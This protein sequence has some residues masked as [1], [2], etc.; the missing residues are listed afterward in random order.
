LTIGQDRIL[1]I[2][3]VPI[4][5]RAVRLGEAW[6]TLVKADRYR[7]DGTPIHG[8]REVDLQAGR[9]LDQA[10]DALWERVDQGALLVHHRAIDVGFLQNAHQRLGRTWPDP[11]VVDTVDVLE[12]RNRRLRQLG[13]DPIPLALGKARARLRLPAA[14]EHRALDDAVATAELWLAL[15]GNPIAGGS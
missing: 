2:A 14:A 12:R 8:I 11:T 4:R 13:H 5:Q 10:L 1:E 15:T 6:S 9:S 3:V 7:A